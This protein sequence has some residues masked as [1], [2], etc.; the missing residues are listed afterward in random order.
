MEEFVI[1]TEN[2]Y[3]GKIVNLKIETVELPNK[4]YS[5]R[6]IVEHPGGVGVVPITEDGKVVLV[7]QFR[8]ATGKTLIEIP[9]GKLEPN[10]EPKETAIRELKEETGYS[11]ENIKFLKEFY[12]SPG[13]CTEKINVFLATD[14]VAGDQNLDENEFL[15]VLELPLEQA[16][17]KIETGEITDAKTI[18]GITFA[19]LE[20]GFN[21]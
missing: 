9:A 7:K 1:K 5:K 2:L 8:I 10:E 11:T 13:Y 4:K 3:E 18:I 20:K 12:V 15:E 6:E 21:E 16:Y 19:M 14:L 17:E